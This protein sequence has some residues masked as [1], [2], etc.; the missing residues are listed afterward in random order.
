M[1]RVLEK[2]RTARRLPNHMMRDR[3]LTSLTQ[4]RFTHAGNFRT[5]V[6]V[7]FYDPFESDE[8]EMKEGGAVSGRKEKQ[9]GEQPLKL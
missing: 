7:I 3:F 1:I 6:A 5:V 2:R 8:R 9:K 4:L